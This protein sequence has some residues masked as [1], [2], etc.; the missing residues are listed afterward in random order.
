MSVIFLPRKVRRLHQ[1]QKDL[2]SPYTYKWDSE[3]LEAQGVN[4][5][6]KRE[7]KNYAKFAENEKL[8]LLYHA[9]NLFEMFPKSWFKDQTQITEFR[10]LASRAGR[11]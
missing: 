9:D 3:F 8:F 4:G 7:W 6:A 10:S 5:Q 2:A 11:A 1:Q